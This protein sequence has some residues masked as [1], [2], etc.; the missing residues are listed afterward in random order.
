MTWSA[1]LQ[2]IRTHFQPEA[3]IFNMQ[4]HDAQDAH[5]AQICTECK[6]AKTSKYA[7]VVLVVSRVRVCTSQPANGWQADRQTVSNPK[8]EGSRGHHQRKS[9]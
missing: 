7:R 3:N 9:P 5:D 8:L 6:N 4:E 1:S 2:N